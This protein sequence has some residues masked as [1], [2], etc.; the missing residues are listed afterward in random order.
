MNSNN[1]ENINIVVIYYSVSGHTRAVA[2]TIQKYTGGE[3]KEIEIIKPYS[4]VGS[5]TR[6]LVDTFRKKLPELKG[7]IDLS[8]YDIIYLGGSTWG[9]D[10]NPILKSFLKQYD[11][12]GKT[13]I[14]FCSDQGGPGKFFEEF[15]T[16]CIGADVKIGHEFIYP[17][18]KS[19]SELDSE[20]ET[21]L[22]NL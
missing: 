15:S 3:I 5:V 19:E 17:K 7:Q 12:T 6:G 4:F 10:V 22:K 2:R 20:V 21:W 14:P 18:Q 13:V 16:L 8:P 1:N 9:Y 11:L